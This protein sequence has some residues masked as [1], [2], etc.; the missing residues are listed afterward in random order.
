M[1]RLK[2]S[3]R[4]IA[5][6]EKEGRKTLAWQKNPTPYRVWVSEVMLQ[7]TQVATV[8]PYFERFMHAF[9]TLD[10]LAKASIESVFQQWA[11][12]GY[13]R[14]A[15]HLHQ[16]AILIKE[17][18]QGIFPTDYASILALPGIGRSTAGAILSMSM[19]QS[20]PIL[21]GNVKRVLARHF[22]IAGWPGDPVVNK[23]L[24]A[25]SAVNTPK[26][27]VHHYT[28]GMMDLGATLCTASNPHCGRCPVASS[29]QAKALGQV[30]QI[31]AKRP[32][33]TMPIKA[34]RFLM[35]VHA[36]SQGVLLEKRPSTGIWGGLW[37]LI[38]CPLESDLPTWCKTQF[39]LSPKTIRPLEAFRHSFT[40]FH[41]HI[42]PF[43][44]TVAGKKRPPLQA[45]YQW[46]D[47]ADLRAIGLPAPIKRLLSSEDIVSA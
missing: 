31:P 23:Q 46:H 3:T 4:V 7:Q 43:I 1:A 33:K 8:I 13:Y 21:D 29:C 38:E 26:K 42:H 30:H 15:R 10:H 5:W 44:C 39:K 19:Q 24:W 34:S 40:H 16:S 32:K 9:P 22:G 27:D 11:G 20:Y 37:S 25:L 45:P 2:F 47:L 12:L 36:T 14:R 18:Y 6:F 35:I 17:H 41:L 28:Q